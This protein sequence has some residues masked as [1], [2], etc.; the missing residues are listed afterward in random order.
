MKLLNSVSSIYPFRVLCILATTGLAINCFVKYLQ[1]E[2][3]A[4]ISYKKY[5]HENKDNIYPSISFCIKNPFLEEELKQYGDEVNVTSYSKFLKGLHWD[6]RMFNISYDKVTVSLKDTLISILIVL[7]NHKKYIYDHVEETQESKDWIPMFYV[8]FRS[9]VRKCFTFDVPFIE[10]QSVFSMNIMFKKSMFP[11]GIIPHDG[12]GFST[13]LHLPGQRFT[14][15]YTIK[16][17][18][19]LKPNTT[20]NPRM[21]YKIQNVEA[22][23]RR[24][25]RKNRCIEDWRNYDQVI[26]DEIMSNAKCRPPH[27]STTKNLSLCSTALEMEYFKDEPRNSKL[28]TFPPSCRVIQSIL[29]EVAPEDSTY[30]INLIPGK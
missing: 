9:S 18:W 16:Y 13:Y 28:D 22:L 14:S 15:Y 23:R 21:V 4:Q 25:T 17:D 11:M 27:W 24:N 5:H 26:M 30:L 29:Y 3:V 20:L 6:K 8:N 19:D 12:N 10:K 2:D 7:N 1:N